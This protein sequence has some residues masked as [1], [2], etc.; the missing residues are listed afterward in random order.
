MSKNIVKT[1]LVGSS[2][3]I[4]PL[5]YLGLSYNK[6]DCNQTNQMKINYATLVMYLPIMYGLVY[7]IIS[8]SLEKV[9]KNQQ[10]R[11]FVIGAIAGELYSLIGHFGLKI[12]ETL[13]ISKNPNMVHVIAP[14]TYSLIYGIFVH[15]L[16][17]NI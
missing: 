16:E 14:V 9:I 11:L 12:P 8:I 7:T 13:L 2:V 15:W 17:K 4:F 6:L 3:S 5:V 1:F 10:T